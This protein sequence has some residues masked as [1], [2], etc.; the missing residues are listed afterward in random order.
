MWLTS[1]TGKISA[2]DCTASGDGWD[3]IAMERHYEVQR[4]LT[5]HVPA[6][7]GD[8]EATVLARPGQEGNFEGLARGEDGH[9]L[10]VNDNDHG[11]K[12]GPTVLVR[13][14]GG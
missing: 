9:I 1:D 8:V 6:R 4:V 14:P 11:G 5:F 12:S 2:M 10:L 13:L 3:V 7:G